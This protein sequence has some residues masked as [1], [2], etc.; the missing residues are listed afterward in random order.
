MQLSALVEIEVQTMKRQKFVYFWSLVGFDLKIWSDASDFTYSHWS[1]LV[2]IDLNVICNRN[3]EHVPV[4]A[5]KKVLE[6]FHA[7]LSPWI[8][9][10]ITLARKVS[11]WHIVFVCLKEWL[12]LKAVPVLPGNFYT[13]LLGSMTPH[14]ARLDFYSKH[15]YTQISPYTFMPVRCTV[16]I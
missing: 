3:F 13:V 1:I 2:H 7:P 9:I 5:F 11:S 14:L 12:L 16:R 10:M 4:E 15:A 8:M 6:F